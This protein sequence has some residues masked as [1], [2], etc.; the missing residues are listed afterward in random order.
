[1]SQATFAILITAVLLNSVA[2]IALKAASRVTGPLE[3]SADTFASTLW[4]LAHIPVL[5]AG[6]ACYGV[7]VLLWIATLSRVEVSL[8]YPMLSLGYI[9]AALA[10]WYFF[11]ESLTLQRIIAICVIIVGV[12]LLAKT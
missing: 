10:G 1:M 2:Q 7:S 9:V 11:D 6:L 8:A 12:Y 4:T 3:L 5:W